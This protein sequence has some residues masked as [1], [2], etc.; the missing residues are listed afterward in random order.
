MS[1]NPLHELAHLA[2]VATTWT[3][4]TGSSH[5]VAPEILR[6]ILG[7]L[8][9]S[10]MN[11]AE[12]SESVWML[13]APAPASDLPPLVIADVGEPI[14]V[15][16]S[17]GDVAAANYRIELENGAVIDGAAMRSDD[18]CWVLPGIGDMGYHRLSFNGRETTLAVAPPR[19]FTIHDI[20]AG[21]TPRLWGLAAPVYAL[22]RKGDGGIGDF[23][24]LSECA[25]AAA[26]L[27]ADAFA[28]NP[29]HAL[30][31]ATPER[32]SPYAPSNR[33]FLNP[34]HADPRTALGPEAVARAAREFDADF[35]RLE[36]LEL[37]DWPEASRA[38][39]RFLC[40]LFDEFSA[41]DGPATASFKSFR[42]N[43]GQ[44]LED[45]ARFETIQSALLPQDTLYGNWRTWPIA[46]QDP[47]GRTVEDFAGTHAGNVAFHIFLQWLADRSLAAA[48]K[49]SRD[50]GMKIGLIAD[51]AV[52]A[53][54]DG[55]YAWSRQ[56]EM[57]PDLS[58]GAPPDLF[59]MHGQSWGIAPFSPRA[60][61]GSGY[62]AFLEAL[63]ATMR[64]AGGIRIDHAMGLAR[65]WV[66]PE[67]ASP[68]EGAYLDYPAHDL[69]RLI[70]LESWR[71]R[72]I[73]MGEDLGTVPPGFRDTLRESGIL[74]MQIMWF[75]RDGG[76]F[77]S[78]HIYSPDAMAMPTTHDLPT[79]AGW[80]RGSDIDD[81]TRAGIL[82]ADEAM[83]ETEERGA[84]RA[85]LWRT[86]TACGTA[87]GD[88]PDASNGEAAVDA[89]SAF[90]GRTP[91][92]LVLFPLADAL[93]L[94]EQ[95]NMP[96]T[97]D[98]YPNWRQRFA[99]T[100]KDI[101]ADDDVRRRLAA[102]SQSR[103]SK[104]S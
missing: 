101:F 30:F 40:E 7:A 63:R 45:H 59:N 25:V 76:G 42:E 72:T 17:N 26:Q 10:A 6:A 65:L 90:I 69:F 29:V 82:D 15:I 92:P 23:S 31:S 22:R 88:P 47:R 9:L 37:I 43:G 50:A 73:V 83:R 71:N 16:A 24:G 84:D 66:V 41:T 95:T 54:A 1:A 75:E 68:S 96:G 19:C 35:E 55:S 79:V 20:G 104:K 60:L 4:A 77:F 70:A 52:G 3:D 64:H 100:A 78:P 81:R 89:A 21:E 38:K 91:S 86:F 34:L 93:G 80:W 32:F 27:G 97:V 51:L 85:A 99:G 49:A 11:D 8:G 53:T 74:G 12:V 2:G 33:A 44:A 18:G 46:M 58:I 102:L 39:L 14:S 28:I 57:L 62:K 67:G 5:M 36:A 13:K 98:E 94:V 56:S 103:P 87:G 48:Q 61:R